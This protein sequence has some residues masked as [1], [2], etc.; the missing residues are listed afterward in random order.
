VRRTRDT[1]D[2]EKP[3]ESEALLRTAIDEADELRQ[4]L[5]ERWEAVAEPIRGRLEKPVA[6]VTRWAL[7]V[8]GLRP[9]R[10]YRQ[11]AYADGNLRAAG[12]SF[13]ALFA[14]F[15]AIWLGFSVIGVWAGGDMRFI[16]ELARF[17]D[18]VV[19]GLI[20]QD[21]VISETTLAQLGGFGWTGLIAAIGLLWTAI[22]W[23]Y[24]TRQ[25]VRAMFGLGRDPRNYV[26][27]K[28]TDLGL[29]GAFGVVLFASA[30]I[31]IAS[32]EALTFIFGLIGVP[33]DSFW[34]TTAA[35]AAGLVIV[36][37]LNMLTL[38]SMYR[39]LSRVAIPW[40]RL[41][42]GTFLGGV[43]LG[44]LAALSGAIFTGASRNPLFAS[45]TVII[46]LLLYL[47]IV[48]RVMLLGASWIAIGMKDNGISPR[49]L[50]REQLARERAAEELHARIVVAR[51]DAEHAQAALARA[52][53]FGRLTARRTLT[54][55]E[56]RLAELEGEQQT[57]HDA[58][59]RRRIGFDV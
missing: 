59:A 1:Q 50:T 3:T 32:T 55:A 7:W 22:A 8:Q 25:A 54:N 9:Y 34:F 18:T 29:A 10:V 45:I 12:M 39:V 33:D 24:Y 6:R 13:Q 46:G 36:V 53:W 16:T 51:S 31:S 58:S 14:L 56:R 11:Y 43:A 42:A 35:R 26:L 30:L 49:R 17:I 5:G 21:G 23:L 19:P 37:A 4:S 15:A 38:G 28:I 48:S 27:Q 44:G 40:R 41:L 52:G 47:N 20:G 57:V 2:E